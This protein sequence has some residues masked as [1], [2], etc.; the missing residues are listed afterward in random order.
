MKAPHP[1][2]AGAS[3]K[4]WKLAGPCRAG[5]FGKSFGSEGGEQK[6]GMH[7]EEWEWEGRGGLLLGGKVTW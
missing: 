2:W 3:F 4:P 6:G 1:L 7:P 5:K